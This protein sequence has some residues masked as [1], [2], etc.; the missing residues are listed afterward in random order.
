MIYL[1]VGEE[2]WP[3]WTIFEAFWAV[4]GVILVFFLAIFQDFLPVNLVF[5]FLLL[6]GHLGYPKM[7]IF[8]YFLLNV[9]IFCYFLDW[10]ISFAHLGRKIWVGT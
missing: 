7:A 9:V 6:S 5:T 1:I 2:K 4:L 3:F 8:T 10:P